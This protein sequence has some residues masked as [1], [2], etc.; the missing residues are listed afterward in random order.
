MPPRCAVTTCW[1]FALTP[2]P[3]L[4]AGC[5]PADRSGDTVTTGTLYEEMR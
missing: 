5:G 2:I 1:I 3:I 4:I